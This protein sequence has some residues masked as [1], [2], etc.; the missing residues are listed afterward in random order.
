MDG[1]NISFSTIGLHDAHPQRGRPQRVDKVEVVIFLHLTA[2]IV[3]GRPIAL[4]LALDRDNEDFIWF[5]LNR[6]RDIECLECSSDVFLLPKYLS[7]FL[8]YKEY[9]IILFYYLNRHSYLFFII[10][11]F[12]NLLNRRNGDNFVAQHRLTNGIKMQW[13]DAHYLY[14]QLE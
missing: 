9:T 6:C 13:M 5:K 2:N 10:F 14:G 8:N 3:F 7:R 12:D 11:L 4:E 1:L